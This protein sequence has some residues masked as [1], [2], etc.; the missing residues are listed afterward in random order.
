MVFGLFNWDMLFFSIL[1]LLLLGKDAIG[2]FWVI[3]LLDTLKFGLGPAI[4]ALAGWCPREVWDWWVLESGLLASCETLSCWMR[5]VGTSGTKWLTPVWASVLSDAEAI[6]FLKLLCAYARAAA[7]ESTTSV[8]APALALKF[9]E[10]ELCAVNLGCCIF[11]FSLWAA[12]SILWPLPSLYDVSPRLLLLLNVEAP[13]AFYR[14]LDLLCLN[15]EFPLGALLVSVFMVCTLEVMQPLLAFLPAKLFFRIS[16][17]LFAE[18]ILALEATNVSL[19]MFLILLIGIF[20]LFARTPFCGFITTFLFAGWRFIRLELLI[21]WELTIDLRLVLAPPPALKDEILGWTWSYLLNDRDLD[22]L[23][24]FSGFVFWF[25]I[26]WTC[27]FS[28][29]LS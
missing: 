28:D 25:T 15:T 21:P 12:V 11:S 3:I 22:S 4:L 26:F 24:K 13:S 2:W 14:L 1:R 16:K 18:L 10:A 27:I 6:R 17:F 29:V 23:F 19:F 9:L 20:G 5:D 7:L 8:P